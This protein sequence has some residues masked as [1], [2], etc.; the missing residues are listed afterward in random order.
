MVTQGPR[1]LSSVP[2]RKHEVIMAMVTAEE[3][4]SQGGWGNRG[5]KPKSLKHMRTPTE[6]KVR[7]CQST[8]A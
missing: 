5:N 4:I 2:R 1:L 3:P 8:A 7:G 6:Q